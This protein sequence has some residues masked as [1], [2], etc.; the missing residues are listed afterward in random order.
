M[1]GP[2]KE[3]SW[4][5]KFVS[6]MQKGRG[7]MLCLDVV[8]SKMGTTAEEEKSSEIETSGGVALRTAA[9]IKKSRESREEGSKFLQDRTV[10]K[11]ACPG[12]FCDSVV[13][14]TLLEGFCHSLESGG[15]GKLRPNTVVIGYKSD[16]IVCPDPEVRNY[17]AV[18][19]TTLASDVGILVV[20]DDEHCLDL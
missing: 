15:L 3:R 14:P 7:L 18:I 1:C 6:M 13:A 16:W 8:K 20:R 2:L 19:R 9:F 17:E 5:I 11:T 4:L 12:A 10:W